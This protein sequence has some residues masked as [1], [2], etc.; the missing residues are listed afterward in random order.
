VGEED[1]QSK[2]SSKL[3][4]GQHL[5]SKFQESF[6]RKFYFS[7]YNR[8][9]EVKRLLGTSLLPSQQHRN[10]LKTFEHEDEKFNSINPDGSDI[11][12]ELFGNDFCKITHAINVKR[13]QRG[14]DDMYLNRLNALDM[15][16]QAVQNYYVRID[17][18]NNQIEN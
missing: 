17:V 4:K 5:K 6:Q 15:K 9:G 7:H 3:W 16:I 1:S 18:N 2:I 11:F 14:R 13:R 10:A 12:L 8:V